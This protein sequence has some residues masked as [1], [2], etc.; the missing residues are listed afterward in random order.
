MRRGRGERS[1]FERGTVRGDPAVGC[2]QDENRNETSSEHVTIE[3]AGRTDTLWELI[4]PW[5]AAERLELDDLEVVGSGRGRTVRV[6][7]DAEGGVDVDRLAELSEGISRLLDAE[8]DLDGPSRL[9]LS[10][11][12]LERKLR[13]PAHYRK[14]IGREVSV[15]VRDDDTTRVVKGRLVSADD[16]GCTVETD[17]GEHPIPYGDVV[18]ARTVFRWERAPKPGKK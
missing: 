13:R 18:T 11:P 7:V 5:L 6:Y 15:K 14:S 8:T 3:M 1:S 12:G 9:E 10:S 16:D 2:A 4:E 17:D